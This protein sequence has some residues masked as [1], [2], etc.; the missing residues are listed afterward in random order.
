MLTV[1]DLGIDFISIG[2]PRCALSDFIRLARNTGCWKAG[3]EVTEVAIVLIQFPDEDAFYYAY[4]AIRYRAV[5]DGT[6]VMCEI[7]PEALE[8]YFRAHAGRAGLLAAFSAHRKEIESITRQILPHRISA[9]R[10]QI[11]LR[12]CLYKPGKNETDIGHNR[13]N[14]EA[15]RRDEMAITSACLLT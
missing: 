6:W 12:D 10:C 14:V 3:P 4:G 1:N 2:N 15:T 5:V 8:D 13:E 7:S 9:G 11:F